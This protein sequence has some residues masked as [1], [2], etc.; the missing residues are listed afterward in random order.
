[1]IGQSSASWRTLRLR[2][3]AVT[4]LAASLA[5]CTRGCAGEAE[6]AFCDAIER[7]DVTAARQLLDSGRVNLIARNFSG[8]CQP[9][10][11]AFEAAHARSD[12]EKAQSTELTALVVDMAK[13]DGIANT[14]WTRPVTS[15]SD[16]G[17]I[18]P[19]RSS[20]S[21]MRCP[22][23]SAVDNNNA[24]V[25]RALIDAGVDLHDHKAM[26]AVTTAA[27]Q[28]SL[29]L[30]RMMV[31]SGANPN[32]GMPGAVGNR[33]EAIVSYLES[34]GGKEDVDELLVAARR[35]DLQAI[36]A[37]IAR[38]ANLEVMD[39]REL[40]PLMRA[41][42][43]GHPAAI[44]RLAKAG[45]KL[46]AM[47]EGQTA[48]HKAANENQVEVIR[49]LI[50]AGANVNARPDPSANT[51]L[52]VAVGNHAVQAVAALVDGGADAN[53]G[54]DNDTT[55]L[56]LA[57]VRGHLAITRE[58]LRGGA[59]VNE[60][61]G[62]SQQPAIHGSL[63]IC[64]RPLE[65]DDQ[66]DNYRVTLLRTVVEA[67]ADRTARNASG[68]TAIDVVTKALATAEGDFYRACHQAKLDYLRLVS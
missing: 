22:I 54:P 19:T 28:G 31:E 38:G 30:V 27:M 46:E 4:A 29:E 53:A 7:K 40:T 66:N 64:A 45:A 24:A 61:R 1:M 21:G 52:Y 68:E 9:I 14:C 8:R 50:A 37:A 34:N 42:L 23:D 15:S 48:L 41:A 57:I 16:E 20:S 43:Y 25:L 36:D 12:Y 5:A 67:G 6:M 35:G 47:A 51:P 44:A 55:P 10:M 32:W 49:A 60:K 65:G 2:L 56:G 17:W 3:I 33:Q 18:R 63:G 58:L 59:R 11:L 26:N 13:L 62:L 39:G